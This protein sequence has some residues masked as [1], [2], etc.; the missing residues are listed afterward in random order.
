LTLGIAVGGYWSYKVLG[1]GGFWA[2]DPVETSSLIPWLTLTAYL[3]GSYQ[4]R[5]KQALRLYTPSVG[6]ITFILVVYATFITRSGL[7]QSVHAFSETTTGLFLA[8]FLIFGLVMLVF[9]V[10]YH[11]RHYKMEEDESQDHE[12]TI[13]F[14]TVVILSIL[15]FISFWGLTFP[16]I[17]Q[18]VRNQQIAVDP[19]FFN[20]WS[21]PFV[22]ILLGV[23]GFCFAFNKRN[24][25]LLIQISLIFTILTLVLLFITPGKDYMLVEP[26]KSFFVKSS[27]LTRAFASL[28]LLS[29]VPPVI[30]ALIGIG[31]AIRRDLKKLSN[32]KNSLRIWGKHIIHISIIFI[33]AGAVVSTSFEREQVVTFE[34]EEQGIIKMVDEIGI[35]LYRFD[36]HQDRQGF[37]KQAVFVGIY[38]GGTKLSEGVAVFRDSPYGTV[39]DVYI[40]RGISK[41]IYVI[42][43]G[44]VQNPSNPSEILIPLKIKIIPWVMPLWVGIFLMA[45]GMICTLID[46]LRLKRKR[47]KMR[48]MK[49]ESRI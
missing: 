43:Q 6:I 23:L 4:F 8:G 17:S 41:D 10:Y 35:K 46:D 36:V 16:L 18:A 38:S 9:S 24:I 12:R 27:G 25:K 48:R 21:Y 22:L 2:W 45:S 20:L 15:A 5:T 19:E 26:D 49:I 14:I 7:W 37:W 1:W 13:L 11:D 28:S 30:Y 42:F 32:P 47:E 40:D 31:F 3:H 33:L 44:V 34:I 29:L 39:T